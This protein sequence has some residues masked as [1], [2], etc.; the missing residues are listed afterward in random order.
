MLALRKR[1]VIAEGA[2]PTCVST[3]VKIEQSKL[4]DMQKGKIAYDKVLDIRFIS[5]LGL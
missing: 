1:E 5:T 3:G 2:I 4:C